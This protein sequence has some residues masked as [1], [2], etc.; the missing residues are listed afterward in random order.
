[1]I[2]EIQVFNF[3]KKNPNSIFKRQIETNLKI[4]ELW[5]SEDFSKLPDIKRIYL[6]FGHLQS[7]SYSS[8]I[9]LYNQSLIN[10]MTDD[11]NGLYYSTKLLL[12]LEELRFVEIVDNVSLVSLIHAALANEYDLKNKLTTIY[13]SSARRCRRSE[14]IAEAIKCLSTTSNPDQDKRVS[15]LL[16]DLFGSLDFMIFV[17]LVNSF[18]YKAYLAGHDFSLSSKTLKAIIKKIEAMNPA[19]KQLASLDKLKQILFLFENKIDDWNVV[20]QS[21]YEAA[22]NSRLNENYA[23][24][25]SFELW[26]IIR[27][28]ENLS[29]PISVMADKVGLEKTTVANTFRQDFGISPKEYQ[30]NCRISRAGMLLL[31]TDRPL[32]EIALEC[33]FSDLPHMTKFFK[34]KYEVSPSRF[35]KN[36]RLGMIH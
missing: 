18:F 9:E 12:E 21:F 28:P 23:T 10:L 11:R 36:Y 32:T 24:A 15:V 6:S 19:Q 2:D 1:M 33:G 17:Y 22:E 35:R 8:T 16:D 25:K 26:K 27:M 31:K 13:F 14:I 30:I 34:Q 3:I 20:K 29:L 7:I 5:V 4:R